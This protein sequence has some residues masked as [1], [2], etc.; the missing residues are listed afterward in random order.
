[1]GTTVKEL[2]H[3]IPQFRGTASEFAN[4]SYRVKLYLKAAGVSAVLTGEAPAGGAERAAF[5]ALDARRQSLLVSC[6]ADECLEVVR[7]KTTTK[8]MWES[9]ETTFAKKC[10]ADRTITRKQ[11]L[12]SSSRKLKV[13]V[14][15]NVAKE[16]QM[17]IANN[18]GEMTVSLTP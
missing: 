8:Q 5:E 15:I 9:L 3:G 13:P 2:A 10:V 1:M 7:E 4:W 18:V 17:M 6:L 12:L 14:K 16:G 11:S